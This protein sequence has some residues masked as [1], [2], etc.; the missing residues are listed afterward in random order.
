MLDSIV[1]SVALHFRRRVFGHCN[2]CIEV[3]EESVEEKEIPEEE[4]KSVSSPKTAKT[5]A[6]M[7]VRTV[8]KIYGPF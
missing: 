1:V 4:E 3:P 7:K 2:D 8:H 6:N 5:P